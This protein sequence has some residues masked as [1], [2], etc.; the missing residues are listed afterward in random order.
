LC[1][2]LKN[3]KS[4]FTGDLRLVVFTKEE[5]NGMALALGADQASWELDSL[6]GWLHGEYK[7]TYG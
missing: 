6:I 3:L 5:L 4:R 1:N 2:A 7:K